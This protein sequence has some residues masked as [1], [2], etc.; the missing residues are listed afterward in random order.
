M[1]NKTNMEKMSDYKNR[2]R[3]ENS[4]M[5]TPLFQRGS[6]KRNNKKLKQQLK[7]SHAVSSRQVSVDEVLAAEVLHPPGNVRHELHQH[8]RREVLQD[9]EKKQRLVPGTRG[10]QSPALPEPSPPPPPPVGTASAPLSPSLVLIKLSEQTLAQPGSR[11]TLHALTSL[12][13]QQRVVTF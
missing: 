5:L 3:E 8:L 11:E 13:S 10:R 9:R 2:T 7:F 6:R 12:S 1:L 4:W